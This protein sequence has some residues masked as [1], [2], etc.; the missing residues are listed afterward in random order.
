MFFRIIAVLIYLK[1]R[2]V[3]GGKKWEVIKQEA[4]DI[5]NQRRR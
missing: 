1:K 3:N 2:T 4:K 5:I